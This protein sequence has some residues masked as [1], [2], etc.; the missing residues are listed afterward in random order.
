MEQIQNIL[1][2]AISINVLVDKRNAIYKKGAKKDE[3]KS[4]S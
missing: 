3:G 2:T 4:I 1:P